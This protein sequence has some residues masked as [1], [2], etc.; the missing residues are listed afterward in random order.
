MEKIGKTESPLPGNFV[1]WR[2][3]IQKYIG[4][5]IPH[6][7]E[8]CPAG[9]KS[10]PACR[11]INIFSRPA[12]KRNH[13]YYHIFKWHVVDLNSRAIE[14]GWVWWHWSK[15]DNYRK[16][17]TCNLEGE[18]INRKSSIQLENEQKAQ[19][20]YTIDDAYL[21]TIDHAIYTRCTQASVTL[22]FMCCN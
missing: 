1:I 20:N 9:G 3:K 4:E 8:I 7:R 13:E 12:F 19:S 16:H 11:E 15:T 2:E 17:T 5:T 18:E 10:C 6:W 21:K 14:T 22:T